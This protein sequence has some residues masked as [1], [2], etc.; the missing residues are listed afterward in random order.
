MLIIGIVLFTSLK[1]ISQDEQSI[2]D[3]LQSA[4]KKV[5]QL[6]TSE[7]NDTLK[8]TILQ[9]LVENIYEDNVWIKYNTSIKSLSKRLLHSKNKKIKELAES[10]YALSLNDE[11]IYE[12]NKGN[13]V[14]AKKLFFTSAEQLNKLNDHENFAMA[15]NNIGYAYKADGDLVKALDF[16]LRSL[17]IREDIKDESGIAMSLNNIGLVYDMQGNIKLAKDYYLRCSEILEKHGDKYQLSS[18]LNNLANIYSRER[19]F[20]KAIELY[21]RSKM[22]QKSIGDINGEAY[23]YVNMGT[24]YQSISKNDEAIA[25]YKKGLELFKSLKFNEGIAWGFINLGNIHLAIGKYKESKHFLDSATYYSNILNQPELIQK[26]EDSYYQLDS[27]RGNFIG[28]FEHYKKYIFYRDSITNNES[29]KRNIKQQLNYE[30][31]K[32]EAVLKEQQLKEKIITEERSRKQQLIIWVV[33]IILAL[34]FFFTLFILRT[35]SLTKKQKTIIEKQ[36]ELVEEKQKEILD[37]IRYAKRIQEALLT[38]QNYIERNLQR[39]KQQ[40]C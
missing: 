16:Y 18:T 7:T 19:Y 33:I 39:L 11:G 31:D 17:K 30:F 26:T 12:S 24:V 37:S 27:A 13:N 3:S 1:G 8:V 4:L 14:L 22:L 25:Y 35:L 40:W 5:N 6:P 28:A 9:G 34:V 21:V 29:Q 20:N 15:L 36:K 10:A 2:I 32:K 23:T 38:S